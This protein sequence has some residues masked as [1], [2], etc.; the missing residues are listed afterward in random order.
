MAS[1]CRRRRCPC[2]EVN[3][4]SA[5]SA[6]SDVAT[7]VMLLLAGLVGEDAAAARIGI[8]GAALRAVLAELGLADGAMVPCRVDERLALA[9]VDI[10]RDDFA[11]PRFDDV[12]ERHVRGYP[13]PAGPVFRLPA[14]EV[15]AGADAAG[16]GP[17]GIIAHGGRCGSALLCN[18]L[19]ASGGWVAIKEPEVINRLLLRLPH[20]PDTAR[21]GALVAAVLRSLAHGTRHDAAGTARRCVVKLSSWNLLYADAFVARLPATPMVVVTRDP[22]ATVASSLDQLP[23]WYRAG[24]GLPAADDRLGLARLFAGEWNGVVTA[25]LRLPV[26]PLFVDYATLVADPVGVLGRVRRHFDDGGPG[27]GRH[28]EAVM[29][30]YSKA[31][32]REAFEPR[33]IHR[34]RV[35]PDDLRAAVTAMT[36]ATWSRLATAAACGT[37]GA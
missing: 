34:R 35:L 27:A 37:F 14:D 3:A 17:A 9:W 4:I 18:L 13:P 8:D 25:A 19:A 12:V 36:A 28:V 11:V 29:Q 32:G 5:L 26:P 22:W 20:E 7:T 6:E 30:Q 16:A 1:W 31:A 10:G 33:G 15:L 23:D 24:T 2:A 21:I